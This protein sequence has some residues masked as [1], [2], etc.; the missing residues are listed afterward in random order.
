VLNFLKIGID[1]VATINDLIVQ[2]VEPLF[3]LDYYGCS[4]LDVKVATG[5]VSGI[6][7]GCI[8]S[9]C[10][11]I[12]GETAEMPGMYQGGMLSYSSNLS[13]DLISLMSKD[14]DLAGFALGAVSKSL[15]L[16]KLSEMKQGDILLG[17]SSTGIHSNG[18]SLI[19]KIMSLQG[20]TTSSPCP[21][22]TSK[23]YPT[24]GHA[25]LEP[26]A[27]YSQLIPLCKKGLIKGIS[28]ITGGG[29]VENIPRMLP[30]GLGCEIDTKT[31]K[32]PDVFKWLMKTGGLDA[33]ET[34]RTFNC[35]IGMVM[36]VGE[37]MADGVERE[38]KANGKGEVYRIGKLGGTRLELRGLENWPE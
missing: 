20:V 17:L 24:L 9:G 36:V 34:A 21:F 19:R 6:V 33:K 3:F 30:K 35:G 25:L 8:Q 29:F 28:H 37:D 15:L 18:F 22:P 32:L 16:P 2:G 31:W 27:I 10:A 11:L 1:L 12:G 5:V 23:Q 4:K 38:L 13:F 14:Y 26:T 7:N